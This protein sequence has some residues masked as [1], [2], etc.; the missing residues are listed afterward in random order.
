MTKI[1]VDDHTE[2][3]VAIE[4]DRIEIVVD[5]SKPRTIEIYILDDNGDRI[6]GGTFDKAQFM[7][8]VMSF[9]NTHY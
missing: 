4:L 2:R 3:G 9:Y 8:I 7:R 6:E 5:D 1:K